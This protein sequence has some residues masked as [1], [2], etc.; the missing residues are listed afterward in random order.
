ML[1]Q[2]GVPDRD[3]IHSRFPEDEGTLVRA[4]AIT[5]CY[6]EIPC[7]PCETSCPFGAITVG[8]D[9]NT[10]PRVDFDTCTGC[11]ICVYSCPG[12]AIFT[13]QTKGDHLL[14]TIPY[15]FVPRP[16]VGE[17]MHAVDR[18]GEIIGTC[19]IVKVTD[20]ARQDK[21]ALLTVKVDREHLYDFIT[22]R[23][24]P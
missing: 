14:F 24:M 10:P 18:A 11:G 19:E 21:T 12:L 16:A 15:E 7:N 1:K 17:I 3:L 13:V 23:R 2:T 4:K 22:V 6:E 9:I 20:R 5:E 8:A